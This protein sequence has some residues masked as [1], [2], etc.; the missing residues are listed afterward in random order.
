MASAL[1]LM[2]ANENP[3]HTHERRPLG[4]E[5]RHEDGWGAAWCDGQSMRVRHSVHSCLNDPHFMM[6][7]G[8]ETDILVLHARRASRPGSV[9]LENTHPFLVE[10]EGRSWAFCHNGA[11]HGLDQLLPAMGL[12]PAGDIDSERL[13]HH[14]LNHLDPVDPV[15]SVIASLDR[16][17]DYTALHSFLASSDGVIATAKRHPEK[18]LPRY[19]ALWE[20]TGRNL[21]VVSSEPIEGI[22]CASWQEIP[23][24]GAVVLKRGAPNLLPAHG[25]S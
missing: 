17:R 19:H 24:P 5:Y 4:A 15:G 11:V 9:R 1:Q 16:I 13:F 8:L 6:L 7:R 25:R 22:G 21:H 12:I 10:Y 3:A 2:A 23:D 18:G 20:G 14:V